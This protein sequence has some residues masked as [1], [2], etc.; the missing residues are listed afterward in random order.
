MSHLADFSWFSDLSR[1]F[2]RRGGALLRVAGFAGVVLPLVLPCAF[3]A[4]PTPAGP[5]W[6]QFGGSRGRLASNDAGPASISVPAWTFA[7]DTGGNAITFLG[8][9]GPAVSRDSVLA[10][11]SITVS[12]Q[13]QFKLWAIDRRT[14][15]ARWSA[16]IA[17]PYVDSWSSPAVDV[18]AST[19]I[20]ATGTT[21]AAF[22]LS[23]GA[24]KWQAT[25][26]APVVNASP[27]V[28]SGHGVGPQ[29]GQWHGGLGVANR[30][31]VTEYDGFG[32]DGSLTC[33]NSDPF[34]AGA[35]PNLPG[36]VLWSVPIGGS[37]GNTPAYSDGMVYVATIGP[38]GFGAGRILAFRADSPAAP[39][40]VWVFDNVIQEGFFGGLCV[41]PSSNEAHA[42]KSIYAASYA[43]FGGRASSNL[44]KLDAAT[45]ALRWSIACNRT[46]ATPV[47]LADGRI[48]VSGGV[49]GFGTVPTLQVFKDQGS[50]ATLLWD[51]AAATWADA[52]GNG[53]MDLG[54]YLAI[55][56][57]SMQPAFAA[58]PT[59]P[60]LFVGS[61]P[62]NPASNAACTDLYAIDTNK[63]P[64]TV[65]GAAQP[66]Y[67]AMHYVGAGSTP[68][69]ADSNLY[70]IGA[71][72]LLAFGPPPPRCDV[73][74]DG[75]V[76]I[77]DLYSWSRGTGQRDVNNDGLVNDS[78]RA[79]LGAELRRDELLDATAGRRP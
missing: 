62:T 50:S 8:Q 33:I 58:S 69:L 74:G 56:G 45:G 13:T 72:G 63:L 24:T 17:A 35:N 31:F 54:E 76:D 68:A 66:G 22:D 29:G 47:V 52:N 19:A 38:T 64:L 42:P 75:A 51:S 25:L 20:V 6:P 41:I 36:A 78:D 18:R 44:V 11:G 27:L 59:I 23:N 55:G 39:D 2:G 37:S 21:V 28:T 46:S 26:A 7:A 10:V 79:V 70:T 5:E 57:W 49:R 61:I 34:Q 71:S 15:L 16:P 9:S 77:E 3:A 40:P 12:S 60:R 4:R 65:A 73:N 32:T 14:G 1:P 67:L 43:F 53:V 30:V 48:L